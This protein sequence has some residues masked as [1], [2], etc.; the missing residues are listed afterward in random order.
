MTGAPVPPLSVAC[1]SGS[2][3]LLFVSNAPAIVKEELAVRRRVQSGKLLSQN[4][5]IKLL[6]PAQFQQIVHLRRRLAFRHLENGLELS[7][8]PRGIKNSLFPQALH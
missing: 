4:G 5:E 8:H 3:R 7:P 2:F 1:A 6:L